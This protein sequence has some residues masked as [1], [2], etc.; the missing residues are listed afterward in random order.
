MLD[1]IVRISRAAR[2]ATRECIAAE[3]V[4]HLGDV[5]VVVLSEPIRALLC[6]GPMGARSAT[7]RASG[8]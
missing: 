6:F 3:A 4:L 7:V 1:A 5:I 2:A 8:S